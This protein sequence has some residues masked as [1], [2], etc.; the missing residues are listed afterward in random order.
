MDKLNKVKD[1][2]SSIT[3]TTTDE[4][5]STLKSEIMDLKLQ[6]STQ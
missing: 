6:E 1:K 4:K 2:I 3:E 5:L